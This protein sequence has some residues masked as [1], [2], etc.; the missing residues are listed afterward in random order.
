MKEPYFTLMNGHVGSLQKCLKYLVDGVVSCYI[1]HICNYLTICISRGN[2]SMMATG[3]VYFIWNRFISMD[4]SI[5]A[6][7]IFQLNQEIFGESKNLGIQHF[8]W[9]KGACN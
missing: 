6:S 8:N 2:E 7:Q 5:G 3:R 9:G 1:L 4:F